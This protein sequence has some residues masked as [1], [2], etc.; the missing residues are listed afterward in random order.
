MRLAVHFDVKRL[1]KRVGLLIGI[2]AIMA[3][4]VYLGKFG[5]DIFLNYE[6][7][8]QSLVAVL[9]LAIIGGL[10]YMVL[11]LKTR[12]ADDLLGSTAVKIRNKLHLK[13]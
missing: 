8:I 3:L 10:V 5:L 9:I 6:S 1:L 4:V 7:R 12:I 2:T 13:L 11:T